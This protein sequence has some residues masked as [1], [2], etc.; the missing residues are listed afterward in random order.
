MS[1]AD[2][3]LLT[4]IVHEDLQNRVGARIASALTDAELDEFE[5]LYASTDDQA[6]LVW[7]E[8]TVPNFK[9]AVLDETQEV[10]ADLDYEFRRVRLPTR[11]TP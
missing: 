7:L 2:L 4:A 11:T 1:D 8:K 5:T 9:Q 10:L 3:Q 6:R